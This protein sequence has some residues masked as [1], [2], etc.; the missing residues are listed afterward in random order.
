MPDKAANIMITCP[1]CFHKYNQKLVHFRIRHYEGS[2]GGGFRT[3]TTT[4]NTLFK[5]GQSEK[6]KKYWDKFEGTT[7]DPKLEKESWRQVPIYE[8]PIL[9]PA[10]PAHQ[11]YL[12]VKNPDAQTDN[13][14]YHI[15]DI[16]NHEL[17]GE[18]RIGDAEKYFRVEGQMVKSVAD[19]VSHRETMLRVCP[20]C[21]NPLPL[22]YGAYEPKFISVI[23]VTGAG[24][25]IYL[26]QLL[27]Y[28]PQYA[29][30]VD[31]YPFPMSTDTSDFFNKINPVVEGKKLPTPTMKRKMLQP[32]FYDLSH[33]KQDQNGGMTPVRETLVLY[34]IAGENCVE[35]QSMADYGDFVTNSD[36][37]ILL[38]DP[39][40]L[41]LLN[42]NI[43]DANVN[44]DAEE[45]N[46]EEALVTIHNFFNAGRQ[47]EMCDIPIAIC[48]SKSDTFEDA[49]PDIAKLEIT[50]VTDRYGTYRSL[51]NATE[52]NELEPE[53]LRLVRNSPMMNILRNNYS[54]YN[55]FAVSSLGCYVR[56]ATAEEGGQGSYLTG[57]ASPRRIGEPL[58]WLF[59]KFGYI[60][61]DKPIRLPVRRPLPWVEESVI[62]G[63]RFGL[64]PVKE[65]QRRQ[66]REE[67]LTED[68]LER[69]WYEE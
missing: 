40:S 54:N 35:A 32:L 12:E 41:N 28:L 18:Y 21:N 10:N 62:V 63:K 65:L 13:G 4:S 56:K 3:G 17:P 51:F 69:L 43:D 47:T 26:S 14:V 66:L 37:I 5:P 36:G 23:G 2:G 1:Y 64:I 39:A 24:K 57:P 52:Y 59:K 6:Y 50:P 48:L 20:V 46:A 8:L 53:I 67:E 11:A 27:K 19:T 7:E 15:Y 60:K 38:V 55:L 42:V 49:L 33:S 61:S 58:L 9:D 44:H 31:M 29:S 68:Q 34:D 25:T 22:G 16:D 45:F 30:F